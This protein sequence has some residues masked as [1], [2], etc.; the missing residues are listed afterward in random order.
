MRKSVIA[1]AALAVAL[2]TL[3]LAE[4]GKGPTPMSDAEMDATTAGFTLNTNGAGGINAAGNKPLPVG[5]DRG[6]GANGRSTGVVGQTP[7]ARGQ[8]IEP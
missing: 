3:A 2:P 4:D 7:S 1:I 6:T 8:V 5:I